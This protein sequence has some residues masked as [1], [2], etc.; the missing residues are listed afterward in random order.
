[1]NGTSAKQKA[2]SAIEGITEE[3]TDAMMAMM[4]LQ[5]A[6][7]G[8]GGGPLPEPAGGDVG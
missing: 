2:K 8:N 1:M 3:Q 4:P 5:A 7:E 6:N